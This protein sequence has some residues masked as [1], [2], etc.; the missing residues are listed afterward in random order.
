MRLL[1]RSNNEPVSPINTFAGCKLNIKNPN[2][3]PI[4]I[5]PNIDTS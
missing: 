5:L 4:T 1:L 3:A 2:V